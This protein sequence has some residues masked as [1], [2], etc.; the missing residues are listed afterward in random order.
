MRYSLSVLCLCATL[1]LAAQDALPAEKSTNQAVPSRPVYRYLFLI[2]TSK[3]MSRQKAVILDTVSRLILSGIGGR[4]KTGDAWNVW[5]L[6]EELHTNLFPPQQWDDQQR[7]EV[8][9]RVYRFLEAQR[10]NQKKSPLDGSLALLAEEAKISGTLTVFL[11]TDGSAPVKGTVFDG[12]I[13][14]IFTQHAAAM[15][16]AKKPFVTVFVAQDGRFAAHAVSPGG[17]RIYIPR[18]PEPVAI[19]KKPEANEKPSGATVLPS[20]A[21]TTLTAEEISELL[22]R[23]SQKR[24]SN[25]I[26]IPAPL[27]IRGTPEPIPTNAPGKAALENPAPTSTP[28]QPAPAST[29]SPEPSVSVAKAQPVNAVPANPPSTNPSSANP[30]PANSAPAN[31]APVNPPPVNPAPANPASVNST[32]AT[33][34]LANPPPTNPPIANSPVPN[35]PVARAQTEPGAPAQKSAADSREAKVPLASPEDQT[36]TVATDASAGDASETLAPASAPAQTAVLAQ[37][38]LFSNAQIYLMAAVGL[39]LVALLLAWLYIRSIR[40]V[41]RPSIISQSFER[42]KK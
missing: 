9:N 37:P 22:L 40:Y 5:T 10:F 39:L 41:P 19:A 1:N 16:K 4:I 3:A 23:Q 29:V 13:N 18:L 11:F 36:P 35:S 2:D 31:P 12:P 6:D 34:A 27:I 17:E 38:Q 30:A 14:A 42:Q 25:S 20:Q 8:A 32:V 26:T 15:R 28:P 33:P 21:K 7:V 24:Q